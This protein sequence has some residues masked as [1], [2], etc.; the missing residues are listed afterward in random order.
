MREGIILIAVYSCNL[1][2]K[3]LMRISVPSTNCG[4]VFYI[5]LTA[6][7]TICTSKNKYNKVMCSVL[8]AQ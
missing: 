5:A 1:N 8:V 7:A 6:M 4:A 3:M 2:N